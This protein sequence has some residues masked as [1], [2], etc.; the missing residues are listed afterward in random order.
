MTDKTD[1]KL[2]PVIGMLFVALLL[3]SN[4]IAVKI[5]QMGGFML[6][7]GI[8]CFP[9]TYIFGDVLVEVYGF[10]RSRTVI[11]CGF[12]CL[13]LMSFF[14][15][16]STTLTPAPFWKGQES[17]SQFFGLAPRIAIASFI[18]YLI[19]EFANSIVMSR[20]KIWSKGKHLWMRT[21]GST[22]VGEGLD[23][24]VFNFAAFLFVFEFKQVMF[25]AFS[26]YVLKVAY[27]V[28]ATPFTY[29]IV[30]YLKKVEGFDHFD[31]GVNYSP[32]GGE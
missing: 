28:V 25:I 16:L 22:I 2:F 3:I 32:L 5:V 14:Y 13:A 20:M 8:L 27:E 11:W 29:M 19:G 6:P 7:A 12:G 15:W 9:V 17:Y 31:H 24:L 21:I 26:G 30:A 10:K 4:T 1:T 18:A 23:S